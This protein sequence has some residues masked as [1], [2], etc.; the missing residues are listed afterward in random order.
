VQYINL[1]RRRHG[2]RLIDGNG[3][4]HVEFGNCGAVLQRTGGVP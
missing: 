4:F 2:G 1:D 3:G